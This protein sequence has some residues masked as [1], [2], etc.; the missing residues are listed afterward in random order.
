MIRVLS[1]RHYVQWDRFPSLLL[2]LWPVYSSHPT[3]Q[4]L[5]DRTVHIAVVGRGLV[6]SE[7]TLQ[8]FWGSDASP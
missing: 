4:A 8:G 5:G 2:V 3:D 1:V 7:R 6:T